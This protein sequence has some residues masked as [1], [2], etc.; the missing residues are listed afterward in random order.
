MGFMERLH[1][2]E[3]APSTYAFSEGGFG[4]YFLMVSSRQKK[5]TRFMPGGLS[6]L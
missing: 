6:A 1:N 2:A 3:P 4:V 5:A